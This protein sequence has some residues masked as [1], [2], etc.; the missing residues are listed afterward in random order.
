MLDKRDQARKPEKG[1]QKDQEYMEN[2][3]F[4]ITGEREDLAI[5]TVI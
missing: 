3:T 4:L 1:Q 2:R 5:M